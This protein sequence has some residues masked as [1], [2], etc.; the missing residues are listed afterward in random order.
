MAAPEFDDD[1]G[2]SLVLVNNE[3]GEEYLNC[4]K[5]NLIIKKTNIEDSMQ[6]SLKAPYPKPLN[7]EQFWSDFS[8]KPFSYITE[9][10][11]M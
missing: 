5:D 6:Q 10:Y 7:R 11:G 9:K 2:V 3:K 4:V 1:K 8:S